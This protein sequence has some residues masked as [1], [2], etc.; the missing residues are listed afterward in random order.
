MTSLSTEMPQLASY[1]VLNRQGETLHRFYLRNLLSS[2]DAVFLEDAGLIEP[3]LIKIKTGEGQDF[4]FEC[5]DFTLE[6]ALMLKEMTAWLS[7]ERK[8]WGQIWDVRD[9]ITDL[10]G[11]PDEHKMVFHPKALEIL[12][13]DSVEEFFED[14]AT[15]WSVLDLD[16]LAIE[17]RL[18]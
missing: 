2:A 6:G 16:I 4:L 11:P 3:S 17:E 7:T 1:V 13:K 15:G 9:H 10:F 8:S 14:A 5:A 12:S 18:L